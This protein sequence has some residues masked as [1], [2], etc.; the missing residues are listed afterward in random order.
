ML[1]ALDVGNSHIFGGVIE[2]ESLRFKFRKTSKT[3]VSSDELGVFLRGVLRENGVAS[4]SIRNI[5]ICTV[6]PDLVHPLRNCCL[7]YFEKEPFVL[8]PGARTGLN[9]KYKNP[10]E[11]GSDRIANAIAAVHLHPGENL[12]V[13][14]LG[15]AN[16]FCAVNKSKDYLG[17]VIMPGL[18]ISM[19]AM[20]TRT[21]KLP[22]VEI[23]RPAELVG[24]TTVDSIQSGL[25]FGNLAAIREISSMIREKYFNSEKA[26]VIGTGGFSRLF[27][28][29][30]IFDEL[31]A[32]LV[33]TGLK[34]AFEMNTAGKKHQEDKNETNTIEIKN[35][36]SPRNRNQSGIQRLHNN[37]P[38]AVRK[39]RPAGI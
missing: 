9:I 16:T 24:R 15:T 28:N 8:Q 22:I 29:E 4:G 35:T 13:I 33:L 6:V 31:N 34:L 23:I 32:D 17:G 26:L 3:D 12:I 5:A 21:A 14:D 2:G 27:E 18:K 36:Q 11:V 1:L 25:Y 30:K 20:A 37:R 38:G 10:A 19:E 39:S 7:K